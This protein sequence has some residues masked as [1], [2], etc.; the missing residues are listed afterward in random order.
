M[1]AP[2]YGGTAT[3][4][5]AGTLVR[6]LDANALAVDATNVY[7]STGADWSTGNASPGEG[8]RGRRLPCDS[9]VSGCL[10]WAGEHRRGC[11]E[12][13]LGHRR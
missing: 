5:A 9:R 3:T 11:H 7:W 2:W 4:L 6:P 8:A 1:G 12:R 10:R 13:L